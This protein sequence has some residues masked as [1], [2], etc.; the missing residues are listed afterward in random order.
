MRTIDLYLDL[1]VGLDVRTVIIRFA[2]ICA[3]ETTFSTGE[4]FHT[5][6]KVRCDLIL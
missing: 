4:K 5:D 2:A 6:P 3:S 1:V